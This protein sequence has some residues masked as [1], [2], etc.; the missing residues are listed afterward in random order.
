M[1]FALKPGSAFVLTVTFCAAP[2]ITSVTGFG[3]AVA[4]NDGGTTIRV[5]LPVPAL[6]ETS[7]IEMGYVP[8]GI[9]AG[10]TNRN[11]VVADV[12]P[13]PNGYVTGDGTVLRPNGQGVPQ[14]VNVPV[15][16]P[17]VGPKVRLTVTGAVVC[18]GKPVTVPG[19]A[20]TVANAGTA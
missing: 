13:A 17:G 3:T 16:G 1:V 19:V 2:P 18:D 8:G 5:T 7:V 9:P 6:F 12:A 10:I 11:D 20:V 4:V 14:N 15:P